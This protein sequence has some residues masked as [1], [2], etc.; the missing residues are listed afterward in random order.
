MYIALRATSLEPKI[1][2]GL[3]LEKRFVRIV[4]FLWVATITYGVLQFIGT[5]DIKL[6]PYLNALFFIPLAPLT[7][8]VVWSLQHEALFYVLF[9]L[10]FLVKRR[11]PW[12]LLAWCAAPA[13]VYELTNF[14]V[15]VG[16]NT[17]LG[18]VGHR[19][20]VDFG[21]GV[22][23]GLLYQRYG[24]NFTLHP[25]LARTLILIGSVG[26]GTAAIADIPALVLAGAA[27]AL[28]AGLKSGS[29]TAGGIRLWQR[30]GDGSYAIYLT[31]NLFLLVGG[32]VWIKIAGQHGYVPA[33]VVL[34]VFAM[35]GGTAVHLLIERPVIRWS[36]HQVERLKR[37][38]SSTRQRQRP[39]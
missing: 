18:F 22:I 9:M 25:V 20:N 15:K 31:H 16:P 11:L 30:L 1:A 35:A 27:V 3:F 8:N 26:A 28:V 29:S 7:P 17:I 5:G 21:V 37:R 6:Q 4:P 19:S 24:F 13:I 38:F 32:I 23:I 39:A 14:G 12:V 36:R 2:P 33:V 34:T 10:T